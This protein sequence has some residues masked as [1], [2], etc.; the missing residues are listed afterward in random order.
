MKITIGGPP[1]SGTTTVA[2]ILAARLNAKLISAG[3]IFRQIAAERGLSVEQL[4]EIAERD[5]S[6]D[7]EIDKR[8]QAYASSLQHAVFE[9]RLSAF[10]VKD[11]TLKIWLKAPLEVRAK[12]VASRDRLRYEE[13]LS[14]IKMREHSEIKRYER[15]YRL[16]PND[17]S[18]YDIVIDSSKFTAED[19]ASLI[20]H[21]L[22]RLRADDDKQANKGSCKAATRT[23][24]VSSERQR[25]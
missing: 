9:G 3:E 4:S 25:H 20:L 1:G 18:A 17:L 11:A 23:A 14:A 6:L 15:Y 24:A 16:N 19:I 5:E 21:A 10:F 12:R 7:R 22:E 8:Q 13:A 2:R